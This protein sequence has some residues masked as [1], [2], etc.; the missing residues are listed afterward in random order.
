MAAAKWPEPL[1]LTVNISSTQ[2]ECSDL[3]DTVATALRKSNLSSS[4]LELE[5]SD[6]PLPGDATKI[7]ENLH[8]LRELKVSLALDDFGASWL[9]QT[10]LGAFRF[11][12]VKIGRS[13]VQNIETSPHSLMIVRAVLGL[14]KGLEIPVTA[15]GVENEA[16]ALALETIGCS[17]LQGNFFSFQGPSVFEPSLES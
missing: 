5:I 6:K 2:L 13:V 4:R 3:A 1:R 17:E 14:A 10:C 12:R 9:S 8:K 15:N 7:L 11:D 16:E